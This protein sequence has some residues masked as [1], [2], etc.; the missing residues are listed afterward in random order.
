MKTKYYIINKSDNLVIQY[1]SL[2]PSAD[3]VWSYLLGRR[4]ENFIVVKS[5]DYGDRVIDLV[6]PSDVQHIQNA[7]EKG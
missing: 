7:C 1:S 5:D 2:N 4:L 3:K 6:I